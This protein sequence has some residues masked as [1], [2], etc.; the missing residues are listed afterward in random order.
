MF[1]GGLRSCEFLTVFDFF[2][3]TAAEI[4][5]GFYFICVPNEL[6]IF[7][8]SG[9]SSSRA[10]SV[11]AGFG[12]F[13]SHPSSPPALQF[14]I[15]LHT[16]ISFLFYCLVLRYVRSFAVLSS[17][18]I[19]IATSDLVSAGISFCTPFFP[20]FQHIYSAVSYRTLWNTDS[21][22]FSQ[23]NCLFST[24]SIARLLSSYLFVWRSN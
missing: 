12:Q 21:D 22:L 8:Y 4:K 18:F 10:Y 13:S 23:R 3:L 2:F 19:G 15:S 20:V 9:D 16:E 17:P 6:K 5:P 11:Y 7:L 14:F 24:T 1:L